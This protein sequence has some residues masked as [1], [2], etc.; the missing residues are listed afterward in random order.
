MR[1]QYFVFEWL[2][3]TAYLNYIK[4]YN[5]ITIS[6]YLGS[7]HQNDADDGFAYDNFNNNFL[8]KLFFGKV[9]YY[10]VLNYKIKTNPT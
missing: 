7:S 4:C 10:G 1:P 9:M 6:S 5:V 2:L 8:V 3:M